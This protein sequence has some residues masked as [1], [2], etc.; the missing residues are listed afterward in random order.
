MKMGYCKVLLT[1]Q[2]SLLQTI[3][4]ELR[5]TGPKLVPFLVTRLLYQEGSEVTW[6]LAVREGVHLTKH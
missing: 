6:G 1:T 2:D 5:S 3:E 4:H